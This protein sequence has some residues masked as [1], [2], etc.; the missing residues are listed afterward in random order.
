M[1]GDA[2]EGFLDRWSRVKRT[3]A[4]SQPEQQP[5]PEASVEP[6]PPKTDPETDGAI[7][8]EPPTLSEEELAALPRIE[9]LVQGSDIRPFLRPGVPRALKNA[10]MRRIWMLT[11]GI[12]DHQ[13]PAVDYAWDWNTP[14]GV[15]GDGVAPSPERTAKML[16]SLLS[17]QQKDPQDDGDA[18]MAEDA[19]EGS[20]SRT[21]AGDETEAPERDATASA[22]PLEDDAP[23]QHD[24]VVDAEALPR[25][26][27]GSALPE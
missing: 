21:P 11:P 6:D 20:G 14:G 12:R 2:P 8:T 13:D 23:R 3:A 25:R 9:D 4:R 27:H 16:K 26:R 5:E 10:A 17:P 19:V 24:S 15:P 7:A 22:Q 1:S 18:A